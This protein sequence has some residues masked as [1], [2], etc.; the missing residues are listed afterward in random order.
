MDMST[1]KIEEM[2]QL[3]KITDFIKGKKEDEKLQKKIRI[4]LICIGALTLVCVAAYVV[5]R[6]MNR[7]DDDYDLYDDLDNYYE[8]DE[9]LEKEEPESAE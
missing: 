4:I 6:L 7:Y 8:E 9:E 1:E 3:S 5:Y 2:L